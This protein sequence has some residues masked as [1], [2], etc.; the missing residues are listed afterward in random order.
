MNTRLLAVLLTAGLACSANDSATVEDIM[1][2]DTQGMLDFTRQ[3]AEGFAIDGS[4]LF[5]EEMKY[6]ASRSIANSG[7]VVF[8]TSVGDVWQHFP[9][10]RTLDF[11]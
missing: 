8:V 7:A 5:I 4:E 9:L 2:P 3:K 10:H 1:I 6:I 11:R